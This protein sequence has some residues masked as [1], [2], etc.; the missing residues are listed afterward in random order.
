MG[1]DGQP[2][3]Y[4]PK[5]D[6]RVIE[7][8]KQ[9]YSVTEMACDI[10]VH[11]DTIYEWR[12]VHPK[13]SDSLARAVQESQAWYEKQGRKGL[14][15]KEFNSPTWA[16][17]VSCRF[18]ADYRETVNSNNTNYNTNVNLGELSKEKTEM[19]VDKLLKEY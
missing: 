4:R 6:K 9:G 5:Y 7:L 16:K 11:K 10:N 19:I 12:K 14:W 18:P 17:Q 15:S 8:G 3:L 2:T 13:F 1:K